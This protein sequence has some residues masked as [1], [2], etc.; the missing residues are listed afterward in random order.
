MCNSADKTGVGPMAAVA[1][2][3]AQKAAE[4]AM[5][6]GETD[7]I[8]ENGGDIYI[9][10]TEP[11]VIGLYVG[12]APISGKLAF[13]IKP[14]TTPQ[15]I[16]SSSAIMGHSLSFGQC[17]LAT[18]TARDA[19]LADTAATMACNMVSAQDDIQPT[20]K[21]VMKIP[22]ISG[23]LIIKDNKIGMAG[24]LPELIRHNDPRFIDKVTREQDVWKL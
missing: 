16:C 20:L 2:A 6:L 14:E 24:D 3:V 5:A 23:I 19:A 10:S 7:V 4:A 17:D 8:V 13:Y 15:S 1:G 21:V 12:K 18:A 22:G 9:V 11:V